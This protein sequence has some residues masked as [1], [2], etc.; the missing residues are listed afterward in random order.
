V[1]FPERFKGVGVGLEKPL[2]DLIYFLSDYII[3]PKE[4]GTEI[5]AVEGGTQKGIFKE[6]CT[7]KLLAGTKETTCYP[8]PVNL[9][10][11]A[12][13]IEK[14][15]STGKRCIIFTGVD[16][17]QT[18]VIDPDLSALTTIHVY[19]ITPPRPHLAETIRELDKTGIFGEYEVR[20]EYHVRDITTIDADIFPCRAAGFTRTLDEDQV[21]AGDTIAGCRTARQV[22]RDG[23]HLGSEVTFHEICP[24]EAVTQEPFIARCCRSE[25]T[26]H[27]TFR[28]FQGGVVHW[29]ANPREIYEMALAVIAGAKKNLKIQRN[30]KHDKNRDC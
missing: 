16:E 25:R 17:H 14:A 13:L 12:D 11:R 22:V 18:F 9:H 20:F 2:G 10:N 4:A 8:E 24:V 5:Y 23:Y 7:L 1:I 6:G 15:A 19:D 3:V 28:G 29:G 30:R 26:G 27:G 21:R